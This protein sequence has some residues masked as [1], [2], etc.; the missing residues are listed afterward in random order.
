MEVFSENFPGFPKNEGKIGFVCYHSIQFSQQY[1]SKCNVVS[2]LALTTNKR[3]QLPVTYIDGQDKVKLGSSPHGQN[4][5][6][7]Y[8][9]NKLTAE[10]GISFCFLCRV[11][12]F[13][14]IFATTNVC[15]YLLHSTSIIAV[16]ITTQR[17]R[18]YS[19]NE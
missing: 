13:I 8:L 15:V 7:H 4:T 16:Q 2:V 11:E 5:R 14:K 18:F 6:S 12:S 17:R 1:L 10:E 3:L 9:A 19:L